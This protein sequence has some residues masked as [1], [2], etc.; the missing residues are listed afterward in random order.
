MNT[1]QDNFL[2][3]SPIVIPD[4]DRFGITGFAKAIASSIKG[5]KTPIGSTI[6]INGAWGSGKSSAINLIKH[7]LQNEIKKEEIVLIDF[8]CWWFHGEEALTLAFLQSVNNALRKKVDKKAKDFLPK[9]GKFLLQTGPV[10][11]PA[12]N[13]ATGGIG[14]SLVSGSMDFAKK[15]FPDEN[16]ENLFNRLF[17]LLESQSNRF[18]VVI[19]DIDRLTPNEAILIFRLIK[20]VGRL[21][22]IIYLLA[23]DRELAEKAV[24][25][26]FPSE[27]SHFLEKIIQASFEIPL[28][29]NEDINTATLFQIQRICGFPNDEAD[30]LDFYNIFYDGVIPFI[31][32]PRDLVRLSNSLS[33]S[34]PAVVGE[35]NLGDY[36]ALEV[37]K[38]FEPKLYNYIRNNKN[39]VCNNG[40]QYTKDEDKIRDLNILVLLVSE[41][42]Q[43]YFSN[44]LKRMFPR[45]DRVNYDSSFYDQWSFR[46]KICIEKHF[47]TYFRM[48]LASERIPAEEIHKIIENA[49]NEEYLISA[50]K[51]AFST[52]L[53]NG[54]S[55][56]PELLE[57]LKI[58]SSEIH[59]KDIKNCICTLFKIADDI[60]REEDSEN[61]FYGFG[62]NYRRIHWLIR[63]LMFDRFSLEQRSSIFISACKEAQVGWLV[64][65]TDSA[66]YDYSPREG[67][68]PNPPEKCLIREEEI[69]ALKA[70]TIEV[71][72]K[73]AGNGTL[74]SHCRIVQI[75]Y[76]WFSLS[77]DNG[78]EV[79]SWVSSHL[80]D[81]TFLVSMASAC[82]GESW[83][84]GMGLFG[85]GDRVAVRNVRASIEGID[86]IL[87]PTLLRSKLQAAIQTRSLAKND[88]M[89]I[90][91]FLEAW[92]QQEKEKKL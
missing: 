92:A 84:Q 51:T 88:S 27:G 16:I 86:K 70:I 46:K 3:D 52:L 75:L 48:A 31:N 69:G 81:N 2:N 72:K 56:I 76:T 82:T 18:L 53:K 64:D 49:G 74:I 90:E 38:L 45:F 71:I 54:K 40:Q 25:E 47:E 23:F 63:R 8:N 87:N 29:S 73:S 67:R 32:K 15:Y 89:K 14:G 60:Y 26:V 19:D 1:M 83:S 20:S 44:S 11:G 36:I 30:L 37:I 85:L 78:D 6:A 33:I 21:P 28:P 24:L 7:Y 66:I 65:F 9:I 5:I 57:E 43:E 61:G 13:L 62:T 77:S 80:D 58:H 17:S 22:N 68:K 35:V 41:D 4:D 12:I 10:I 50:F 79:R 39:K 34:F 42:K 91:T 55:Q 59:E